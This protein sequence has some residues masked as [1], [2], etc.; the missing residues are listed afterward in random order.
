MRSN[1][2]KCS[3]DSLEEIALTPNFINVFKSIFIRSS[4]ACL[5][6]SSSDVVPRKLSEQ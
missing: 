1:Q 6:R 2:N 3:R 5:E 4:S